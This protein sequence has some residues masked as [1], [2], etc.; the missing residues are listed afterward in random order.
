MDLKLYGGGD[1]TE[2]KYLSIRYSPC[3][4]ELRTTA[5]INSGK[6]CLVND[7]NDR[8]MQSKYS[9]SKKYIKD[10]IMKIWYNK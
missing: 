6:K 8:T 1:I 7:F 9:E 10:P 5:N 4:P 2:G 3:K